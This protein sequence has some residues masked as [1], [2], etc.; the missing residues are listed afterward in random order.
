MHVAGSSESYLVNDICD[1]CVV[2]Y[3]TGET[4]KQNNL[5]ILDTLVTSNVNLFVEPSKIDMLY[6]IVDV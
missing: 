3:D 6:K 2:V 5:V 4:L 1:A